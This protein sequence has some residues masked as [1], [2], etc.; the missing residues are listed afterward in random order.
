[1][2]LEVEE[3]EEL[4]AEEEEDLVAEEEEVE[5]LIIVTT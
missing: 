4:V 5:V 2:L 1:M 3:E